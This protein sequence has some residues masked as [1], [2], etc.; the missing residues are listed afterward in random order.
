MQTAPEK[1]REAPPST[2]A[3]ILA[4]AQRV[5]AARGF[6][7]ASTREIA[8]QAGVNIS[9]L[10]YHWESKETLYRGVFESIYERILALASGTIPEDPGERKVDRAAIENSMAA[11]FD[12]FADHPD[13][14]RL[15][16]RRFIENEDGPAEIE[17]DVLAPAWGVFDGWIHERGGGAVAELD[18][19][20]FMLTMYIVVM[21]LV[22][23]SRHAVSLLGG[24]MTDSRTRERV[25]RHVARLV[26]TLLGMP[27]RK[28]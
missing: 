24:S 19:P 14:A 13:I 17:A 28:L 26:P 22:L 4:T 1:R 10:H 3:K 11:L 6:A 8:S 12:F 9:S 5:F 18:V 27:P 7:G 23:D 16:M 21:M 25:R 2:K 15:L 20:L